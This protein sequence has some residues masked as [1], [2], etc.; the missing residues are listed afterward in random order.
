M[1]RDKERV[2][3]HAR[4]MVEGVWEL[5]GMEAG[6]CVF[7]KEKGREKLREEEGEG[8]KLFTLEIGLM[9]LWGLR[10]PTIHCLQAR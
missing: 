7:V 3:V 2:C 4:G 10:I 5:G 6:M 8:K 1:I 9:R